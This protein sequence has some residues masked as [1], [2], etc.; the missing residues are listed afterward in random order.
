ML[1]QAVH[2]WHG[3]LLQCPMVVR[4]MCWYRLSANRPCS[5][6]TFLNVFDLAVCPHYR[7]L[8]DS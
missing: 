7:H 8:T 2:A 5:L 4:W 1:F 6:I 3:M